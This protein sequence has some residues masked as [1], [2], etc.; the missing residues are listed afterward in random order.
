MIAIINCCK[1]K[2]LRKKKVVYSG[3]E[4]TE[5]QSFWRSGLSDW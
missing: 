5:P 4:L 1:C 2:G 3:N